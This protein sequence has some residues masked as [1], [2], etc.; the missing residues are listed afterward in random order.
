MLK[1]YPQFCLCTL[2]LCIHLGFVHSSYLLFHLMIEWHLSKK[3][4]K[5]LR[6]IF[7][8]KTDFKI[9]QFCNIIHTNIFF[10]FNYYKLNCSRLLIL[11]IFYEMAWKVKLLSARTC[12]NL[13]I[14]L[15][16]LACII[17]IA[18]ENVKN[19]TEK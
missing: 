9:S 15:P 13:K 6:I 1:G 2:D 8:Q 18:Q 10:N 16:F 17:G 11:F 3:C 4:F 5:Q 7:F 14:T 12:F 19:K